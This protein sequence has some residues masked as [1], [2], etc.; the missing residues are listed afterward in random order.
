MKI[1]GRADKAEAFLQEIEHAW[2]EEPQVG[3]RCYSR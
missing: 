3:G 2:P 1:H